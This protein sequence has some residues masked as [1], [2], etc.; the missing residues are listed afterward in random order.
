MTRVSYHPTAPADFLRRV[1]VHTFIGGIRVE[2]E[3]CSCTG[4][5]T[6]N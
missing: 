3:G 6:R 2:D 4:S 5:C 1:M